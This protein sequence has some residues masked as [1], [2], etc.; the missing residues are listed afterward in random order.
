MYSFILSTDTISV[1][2]SQF[3]RKMKESCVPIC[4]VQAL[5]QL[6]TLL[7]LKGLSPQHLNLCCLLTL[8]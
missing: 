4:V 2:S 5:K 7:K 8:E 6:L 1:S 3:V